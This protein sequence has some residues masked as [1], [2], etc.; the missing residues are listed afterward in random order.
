MPFCKYFV[1]ILVPCS[2]QN[3][4]M[5]GGENKQCGHCTRRTIFR[6]QGVGGGH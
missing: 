2:K 5:L 1:N 3:G 6:E 4:T